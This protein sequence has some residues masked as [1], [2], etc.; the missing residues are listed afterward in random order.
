MADTKLPFTAWFR[1]MHL[2]TSTKQGI[3]AVE[4]GRRLGVSYPT[5]WYLHKRIRHAMTQE[6]DRCQLS[7]PIEGRSTPIVE[8]D[9]V[10]LGGER[11][12]GS[13]TAGKTRVIA[14]AE[15]HP[16]GRMGAVA[17][18]VVS[19]FSNAE[20]AA[21]RDTHLAAGAK[22]YTDGMPAF[23]AFG[24]GGRTHVATVTGGKRPERERGAP[25]FNV[26][27]LISNLSTSL[28]A[29]FKLFSPKHLPDYLGA[30][31]WTANRRRNMRGM[32]D[33]LCSAAA[34]SSRLTRRTVYA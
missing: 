4:L 29:T 31:C 20:A 10:Y 23:H 33:A 3:S 34:R 7:A 1:A 30:F 22:V 24:E 11:N 9:D 25:F 8:A 2:M 17:M 13:G 21:F 32:V 26:N 28:K 19:G 12:E 27:T 16:S 18:Q 14:A 5:A 15:R 6:S